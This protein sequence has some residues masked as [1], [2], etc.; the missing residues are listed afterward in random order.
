MGFTV[1]Q[2]SSFEGSNVVVLIELFNGPIV[3]CV[4]LRIKQS[5]PERNYQR[6]Y[7][8]RSLSPS[9]YSF[10]KHYLVN[11]REASLVIK[12]QNGLCYYSNVTNL[13]VSLHNFARSRRHELL[14]PCRVPQFFSYQMVIWEE[15]PKG[16]KDKSN[17][18]G[19]NR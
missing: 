3:V 9:L 12:W 1:Y 6:I 4:L 16:K 7:Q 10:L 18:N 8:L 15:G 14:H 19:K 11:N 5:M 13:L 2:V 17:E